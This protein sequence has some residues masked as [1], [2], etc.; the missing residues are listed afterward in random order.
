MTQTYIY[1]PACSGETR[2]RTNIVPCS[3]DPAIASMC[4]CDGSWN[5]PSQWTVDTPCTA[6]CANPNGQKVMQKTF[7]MGPG[8]NE[9]WCSPYGD[10]DTALVPVPCS[11]DPGVSCS[12]PEMVNGTFSINDSQGTP[13]RFGTNFNH[14]TNINAHAQS[15]TEGVYLLTPNLFVLSHSVIQSGT[16]RNALFVYDTSGT[17]YSQY[18]FSGNYVSSQK[19]YCISDKRIIVERNKELH[20]FVL[21]NNNITLLN[22]LDVST[23][24]DSVDVSNS[25]YFQVINLP[26]NNYFGLFYSWNACPLSP[27]DNCN[28]RP[29][30]MSYKYDSPGFNKPIR[31]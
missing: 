26:V 16:E 13:Y 29:R 18:V 7:V 22:T 28:P 25:N 23:S 14:T 15:F 24:F 8:A 12:E 5:E 3:L 21:A 19:T 1:P 30:P 10:G 31:R 2:S 27:Y 9:Q 6:D 11:L 17:Y 4:P 20:L